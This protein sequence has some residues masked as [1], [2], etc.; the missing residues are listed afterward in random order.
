MACPSLDALAAEY[1]ER[2]VQ[3]AFV[4]VR[5]AHPG[6]YFPHHDSME[7]KLAHAREFHRRFNV[8]RPILVDDL[9][10]TAHRAFGMLPNMTYII[11]QRH[12][13][14]FR[15]DWTD[16]SL[17]RIALDYALGTQEQ[18]HNG[19]R[20]APYFAELLGLRQVDQAA[21]D[22]GLLRNGPKAHTE[23]YEAMKRRRRS[24]SPRQED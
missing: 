7:R 3:S 22:A 4:Y 13:N 2:G 17:I 8:Q 15:A 12:T 10:G 9:D 24:T 19:L 23:F 21:F 14:V 6:E 5:E 20:P 16:V 11:D 18:H 1:R